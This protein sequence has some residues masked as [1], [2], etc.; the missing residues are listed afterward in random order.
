MEIWDIIIWI[1]VIKASYFILSWL[2]F[3]VYGHISIENYKYGWIVITGASDG[4]GKAISF[5]LAS[6]GFKLILIARNKSKLEDLIKEITKATNNSSINYIV[7]D[8]SF[9]HRNPEQFYS[10]L[11]SELSIYE[12]SGLINNVG[13][14]N[15][16]NLAEQD[17]EKIENTLGVN[18]YPQTLLT[19]YMLP[20]FLDRYNSK[21]QKSLLV[22]MSSSIDSVVIPTSSVY[23]ATKRY[24]DYLSE[25]VRYEYGHAVDVAT[26]KPGIVETPMT[27]TEIG[28]G[29]SKMPLTVD[30]NSYANYLIKH[31]HKGINY[32][33]WKHEIVVITLT[34][35]P[36]RISTFL[37]KHIFPLLARFGF[38]NKN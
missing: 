36:R 17:L 29:Y 12:I 4:I 11:L 19:Y 20:K 2:Y 26:I 38:P 18:I 34:I 32:G 27:N 33:H 30:A 8:F 16:G 15:M 9:S 22:N 6:R 23:S 3:N 14:G 24:D 5:N 35:I 10:E 7:A 13:V 25:G 21:K 31:L 37:M 1:G 28:N